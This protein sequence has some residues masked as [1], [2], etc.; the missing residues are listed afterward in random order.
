VFGLSTTKKGGPIK[1]YDG[2]ANPH[3]KYTMQCKVH[4][5]EHCEDWLLTT[6]PSSSQVP[7]APA[8]PYSPGLKTEWQPLLL[9]HES[10][11]QMGKS[12]H[13]NLL[14]VQNTEQRG[15]AVRQPVSRGQNCGHMLFFSLLSPS[16]LA[17]SFCQGTL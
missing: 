14:C 10:G 11:V 2:W 12:G 9:G 3:W 4:H 15:L 8:P 1:G 13:S 7:L 6:P 17:S 16:L 5:G